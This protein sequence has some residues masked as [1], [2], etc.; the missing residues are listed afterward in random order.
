VVNPV[1]TEQR[2]S[3]AGV[4]T[5]TRPR[6]TPRGA[7]RLAGPPL[8]AVVVLV[9]AIAYSLVREGGQVVGQAL[10]TGVLVGGVYALVAVGLSL[11]FGVLGVLNFAVGALVTLGMYVSYVLWSNWGIPAIATLPFTIALM[12][13]I[14]AL[15]QWLLLNPSMGRPSENQLL[16][17]LGVALVIQNGLLLVFTATPRSISDSVDVFRLPV[18]DAVIQ[19]DRLVAFV[20]AAVAALAVATLLNRTDLGLR[21]RGVASNPVAAGLVGISPSRIYVITF[22]LGTA[23]LGVASAL[24]LPTSSLTPNVGEVYTIIAF[25]VVV[26]G[27]LGNIRG[28]VVCGLGVGVAQQLGGLIFPSL[29]SMFTV[30]LL[31]LLVIAL[32]PQGL[33]EGNS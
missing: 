11:I 18:V 4:V 9:G 14:G 2:D 29:S 27:G 25:V 5:D 28:S 21:I 19:T 12:F 22:G 32:R 33:F 8:V 13:G 30:Y 31:F 16:I 26:L 1:T 24:I 7:P 6:V 20:G 23:C 3:G 17:T 15:V 10:V